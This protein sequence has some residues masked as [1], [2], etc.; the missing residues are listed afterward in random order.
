[1]LLCD[2]I[3]TARGIVLL[4][5]TDGH[6]HRH[7]VFFDIKTVPFRVVLFES[8]DTVGDGDTGRPIGFQSS[9]I[10]VELVLDPERA[11]NEV[12][13]TAVYLQEIQRRVYVG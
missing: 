2:T 13:E 5:F 9:S 3:H 7:L 1:M 4:T 11:T 8:F 6:P 10:E 12:T